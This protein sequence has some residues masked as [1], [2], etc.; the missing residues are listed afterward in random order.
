MRHS[1]IKIT[2]DYYANVDQAVEDAVFGKPQDAE[3]GPSRNGSRNSQAEQ[4]LDC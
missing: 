2:M 3:D 1:D 4:G